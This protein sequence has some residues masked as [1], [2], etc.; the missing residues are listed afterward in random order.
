MINAID[1]TALFKAV[2]PTTSLFKVLEPAPTTAL[3]PKMALAPTVALAPIVN[4]CPADEYWD[5]IEQACYPKDAPTPLVKPALLSRIAPV[6]MTTTRTPIT[7]D[8]ID[9]NGFSPAPTPAPVVSPIPDS[10]SA[11]STGPQTVT[12]ASPQG[13]GANTTGYN[14]P[15]S[16]QQEQITL[17][18]MEWT[19]GQSLP[20]AP[21]AAAKPFYANPL[22][23][24]GG[25][26]L[27]AYLVLKK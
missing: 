6:T 12:R 25:G 5:K 7:E 1:Y 21:A 17:D 4:R 27:I 24:L 26:A 2:A 22:V 3:A 10:D 8:T 11:P 18:P 23:I 20:H 13:S 14:Y 15:S 16:R 9:E 19:G